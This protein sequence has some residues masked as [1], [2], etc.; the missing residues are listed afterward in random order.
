MNIALN[1]NKEFID[2]FIA[3]EK[4]FLLSISS[5]AYYDKDFRFYMEWFILAIYD[6]MQDEYNIEERFTYY[7]TNNFSLNIMFFTY[8]VCDEFR[9]RV[10]K[11]I[12]EYEKKYN[13]EH[14]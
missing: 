6:N 5:P 12:I 1:K 8:I 2:Y 7:F 9:S 13:V 11:D 4:E 14:I 3:K 10:K